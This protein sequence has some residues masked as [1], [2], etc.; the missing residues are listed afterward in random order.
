VFSSCYHALGKSCRQSVMEDILR[1]RRSLTI[2][3]MAAVSSVALVTICVFIVIQLFHFVE[4]RRDDYA[5]QLENIAHSVARPLS[6]SVLN[7][8]LDETQHILNTLRPVGILNRADVVLPNQIQTLSTH[9]P[10]G[11][12]VP[13]WVTKGFDLPIKVSVPLYSPATNPTTAQPLAYLVLQAD[14]YRMYQFIVSALSTMLTTYLLLALILSIAISWCINRLIIHP[15]R[16]IARELQALPESEVHYHQLAARPRHEDDELGVLIRSYNRNQLLL[17]KALKAMQSTP[18]LS[19]TQQEDDP[20]HAINNND[21]IILLRPQINLLTGKLSGAE[22]FLCRELPDGD[23]GQKND[24][25]VTAKESAAVASQAEKLLE[26]SCRTLADWQRREIKL[27]LAVTLPGV[28]IQRP[29]LLQ[30]LKTLLSLYQIGHGYLMLQITETA[31]I[32]DWESVESA[33][34]ELRALGVSIR[35]VADGVEA[36]PQ[37]DWLLS[38][39]IVFAQGELFSAPL[40]LSE[41]ETKFT[42]K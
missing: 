20:L 2:K 29:R 40:P 14:P 22:A 34:G 33:L 17:D 6:Q 25:I 1:V 37:R 24:L 39:G 19:S 36:E 32:D 27:A 10:E 15:L 13:T 42:S 31:L 38:Q 7:A 11:R 5:Q 12:P 21:F 4:Q 28:Q 41:F 26:L 16:S 9:Y 30:Q 3:Q 35:L 18:Q 8:D 23:Y